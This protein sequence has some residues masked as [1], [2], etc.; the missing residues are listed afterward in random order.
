MTHSQPR[1][2]DPAREAMIQTIIAAAKDSANYSLQIFHDCNPDE[3]ADAIRFGI[4]FPQMPW[5]CP[6]CG[7]VV[8][9][10]DELGYDVAKNEGV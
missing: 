2:P 4:G 10:T 9:S 6:R 7:V 5:T 1:Q 8:N 3:P